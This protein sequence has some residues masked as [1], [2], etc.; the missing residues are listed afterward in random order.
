M[1][2]IEHE[3]QA[4][5]HQPDMIYIQHPLAWLFSKL[6]LVSIEIYLNIPLERNIECNV[7]HKNLQN[8]GQ[9][10][11]FCITEDG[12]PGLHRVVV[13]SPSQSTPGQCSVQMWA[14]VT[15]ETRVTVLRDAGLDTGHE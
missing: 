4:T 3:T 5:W 6:D 1:E 9:Y 8:Q 2:K 11:A 14:S 12:L 15:S 13:V 10:S 7:E